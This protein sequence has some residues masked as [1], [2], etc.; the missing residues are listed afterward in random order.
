MCDLSRKW[1]I[2]S[3]WALVLFPQ[4]SIFMCSAF[5]HQTP[6][7]LVTRALIISVVVAEVVDL[8]TSIHM[9]ECCKLMT[10]FHD[11]VNSVRDT[12]KFFW[13]N[14]IVSYNIALGDLKIWCSCLWVRTHQSCVCTSI[15]LFIKWAATDWS[16]EQTTHLHSL[17][18]FESA[19]WTQSGLLLGVKCHLVWQWSRLA[20][21]CRGW[22]LRLAMLI[23]NWS[24]S[25]RHAE[26]QERGNGQIKS[27]LGDLKLDL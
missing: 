23:A 26:E 8:S 6:K 9:L 16:W 7:K 13:V 22:N 25:K 11:G 14:K 20:T 27:A 19:N 2:S 4:L 18:D 1:P 21:Q 24:S 17:L 15:L 3:K 12:K 10:H 5:N